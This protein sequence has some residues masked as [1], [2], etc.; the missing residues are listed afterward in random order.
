M[1]GLDTVI[2]WLKT[3]MP[4]VLVSS[5]SAGVACLSTA[6]LIIKTM[7]AFDWRDVFASAGFL[8]ALAAVLC[9]W[10]VTLANYW[11]APSVHKLS[12]TESGQAYGRGLSAQLKK[13]TRRR[14]KLLLRGANKP[15]EA[16]TF[17]PY[18]PISRGGG[19]NGAN[20]D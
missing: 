15:L 5:F 8:F 2:E 13:G 17:P 16:I 10:I 20:Q 4:A 12:R 3:K 6:A 9:L 19:V 14:D 11:T 1:A 18:N 7:F